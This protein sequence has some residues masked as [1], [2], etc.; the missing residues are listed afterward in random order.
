MTFGLL[1][2]SLLDVYRRLRDACYLH[3]QGALMLEAANT[4][5]MSVNFHQTTPRNNPETAIFPGIS[6]FFTNNPCAIRRIWCSGLQ[7]SWFHQKNIFSVGPCAILA[8][9]LSQGNSRFRAYSFGELKKWKSDGCNSRL[10][11]GC[12]KTLN[13][14]LSIVST[15]WAAQWGRSLS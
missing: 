5:E 14:M 1:R 3:H 2:R 11:R 8:P 6:Y 4:S 9:L 15:A 12:W 10:C 13:C 7:V